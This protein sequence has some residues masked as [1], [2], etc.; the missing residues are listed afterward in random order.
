MTAVRRHRTGGPDCSRGAPATAGRVRASA[1]LPA[2][3]RLARTPRTRA[4][5]CWPVSV[6]ASGPRRWR[7]HEL[8]L[9]GDRDGALAALR[10]DDPVS[11]YNRF[12]MDPDAEDSGRSCVRDWANSGCWSTSC[13]SRSAA[14]TSRPSSGSATGELAALVLSAQASQA[15]RTTGDPAGASPCS[16]GP[17]TTLPR[18]SQPLSRRAARARRRRIAAHAGDPTPRPAVRGR[19]QGPRRC[20][21]SARRPRRAA[22]APGRAAARAGAERPELLAI[23]MPHYH[24]ALQLVLREE[25]PLLWA[26]A[27]ANLADRVPDDADDRGVRSAAARASP[28][29]RCARR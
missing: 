17:L 25:A 7:A 14:P 9:A 13:C 4:P 29:S 24:S 22:P 8:A 27:H 12:V 28:R 21:R 26:S 18:V 6:P 15:L 3:S 16:T 23:A 19:A 5:R 2:D 10:G 20:R 11:R 1:G